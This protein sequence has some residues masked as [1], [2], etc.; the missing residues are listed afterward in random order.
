ML[1]SYGKI[2]LAVVIGVPGWTVVRGQSQASESNKPAIAGGLAFTAELNTSLDSKKVKAGDAVVA[3]ST[4]ALKVEGKTLLP[5]GTKVIGHIVEARARSKGDQDSLIAIQFDKAVLKNKEEIPVV[6]IVRA[7]ASE[8]HMRADDAGP[9][10]DPLADSRIGT[11]TSP[12]AGARNA[13]P[14]NSTAPGNGTDA[15]DASGGFGADGKLTPTSRGVYGI[16][17]L[18][19]AMDAAKTPPVSVVISTEKSVHLDSGTRLLLFTEASNPE[20]SNP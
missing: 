15:G 1:R 7:I 20:G 14:S 8:P 13:P 17:G 3:Q 11:T 18:K 5:S 16:K 10:A 2:L 12:M 9:G 19:L 6:L 4:A